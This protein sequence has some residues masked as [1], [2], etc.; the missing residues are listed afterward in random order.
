MSMETVETSCRKLNTKLRTN[1]SWKWRCV[2][3]K[4]WTSQIPVATWCS[5]QS[6]GFDPS[7]VN[8]RCFKIWNSYLSHVVFLQCVSFMFPWSLWAIHGYPQV[9]DKAMAIHFHILGYDGNIW[10]YI[11]K[12]GGSTVIWLISYI[13]NMDQYGWF[14]TG[15]WWVN[16]SSIDEE[17]PTG[18]GPKRCLGSLDFRRGERSTPGELEL[19]DVAWLEFHGVS[20]YELVN[21]QWWWR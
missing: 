2:T 8:G 13:P 5:Q 11:P 21:N 19:P 9:L 3:C 7:G 16:S 18:S 6:Q 20:S 15:C 14:H 12:Y 10:Q 17:S 4:D 1:T